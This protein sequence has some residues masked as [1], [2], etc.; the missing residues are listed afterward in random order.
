VANLMTSLLSLHGSCS[1]KLFDGP[2]TLHPVSK[3][4]VRDGV[5]IVVI[6]PTGHSTSQTWNI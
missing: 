1:T 5:A 6:E 3:I 2:C 4:A